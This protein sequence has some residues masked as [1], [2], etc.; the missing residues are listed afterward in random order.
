MGYSTHIKLIEQNHELL[1][2]I[3]A[4]VQAGVVLPVEVSVVDNI[5]SMHYKLRRVLTATN[6]HRTAYGGE[7]AGLGD[8]VKVKVDSANNQLLVVPKSISTPFG[9]FQL[10]VEVGRITEHDAMN[11]IDKYKGDFLTRE[12]WPSP[13]W[14]QDKFQ[15]VLLMAGWDLERIK[16]LAN[17]KIIAD[18][19]KRVSED[20]PVRPPDKFERVQQKP[21][22]QQ[23]RISEE[24]EKLS[25]EF[26]S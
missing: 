25:K 6:R 23:R 20:Q 5:D 16:V 14:D 19:S 17:G 26:G 21:E 18:M 12:F 15:Q 2:A 3:K 9:D 8:A 22:E 13:E 4:A 11:E 7:F 10:P 24:L 1:E